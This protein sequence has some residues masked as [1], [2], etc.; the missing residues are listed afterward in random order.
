MTLVN[1]SFVLKWI[2]KVPFK[3]YYFWCLNSF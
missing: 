2:T 1:M 3:Y